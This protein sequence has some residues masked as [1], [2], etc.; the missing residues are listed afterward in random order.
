MK[1]CSPNGGSGSNDMY[2][3]QIRT[4]YRFIGFDIDDGR[5]GENI[6]A[7]IGSTNR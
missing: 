3:I 6:G 2:C 4:E 5:G 7:A 1:R